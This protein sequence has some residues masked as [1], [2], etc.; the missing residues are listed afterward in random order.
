MIA[1]LAYRPM[2]RLKNLA[3]MRLGQQL[4][5]HQNCWWLVF[6][7]DEMKA[8]RPYEAPFPAALIPALE[9]YLERHCPVLLAGESGKVCAE[10]D[11]FW[12]SEAGT[13]LE[14]GALARRIVRH[15][16]VAFGASV[17]PHL[18]RDAAAT[19]VAVE[20]PKHVRD[21][22]HLLGNSFATAEKHYN[23][24]Q[25]LQASRRHQAM[26]ANLRN[27]LKATLS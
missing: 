5:K 9:T 11:A 21:V 22:H 20:D 6:G 18:F 7:S 3:S 23:Q 13:M 8:Q 27:D 17:S 25:A 19:S 26:L 10:I 2:M 24:A 15:T 4:L 12:V 16:K 1:L 14:T